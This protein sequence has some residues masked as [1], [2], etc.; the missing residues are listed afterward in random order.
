MLVNGVFSALYNAVIAAP[1][2]MAYTQLH[3]APPTRPLTAQTEAG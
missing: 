1:G 3:G 2:A